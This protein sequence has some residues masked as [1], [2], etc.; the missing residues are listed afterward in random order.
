MRNLI[1]N[2][3]KLSTTNEIVQVINPYLGNLLDTIPNSSF[4]DVN[5]AVKIEASK[6][7]LIH[8]HPTGDIVPSSSD[9]KFTKKI[10]QDY[11]D[12]TFADTIVRITS[13]LNE[14]SLSALEKLAEE[15]Q[16]E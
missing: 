7:I 4:D 6:I 1:G 16:R 11:K 5:E 8:N 2:E 3:W 9:I 13:T 12:I 15:L 14:E 10:Y